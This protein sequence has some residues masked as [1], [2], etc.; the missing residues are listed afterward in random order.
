MTGIKKLMYKLG[1]LICLGVVALFFATCEPVPDH[2]GRAELYNPSFQFCFAGKAYNKCSGKTY[3]PLTQGCTDR[4]EVGT[5]CLDSTFVKLGTPCNG[6][7]LSVASAPANGGEVTLTPNRT[8]FAADE[9]VALSATAMDGYMFIGWAGASTSASATIDVRMD[10]NKPLVAIFNPTNT[11]GATTHTLVT[12]AFPEHSGTVFVNSAASTGTTTHDNGAEITVSAKA[13]QGYVFSGWSGALTSE[14]SPTA[15]IM[16]NSKTLVA[17]FTLVVYTLTVGS[18][19]ETGGTVFV[20]GTALK[21]VVEQNVGAR[22][23]VYALPAA[24]Y[25]FTGW[26]VAE[27]GAENPEW[28]TVTES[29]Q[30]LIANFTHTGAIVVNPCADD[31]GSDECCD[32]NPTHLSCVNTFTDGRDG[33]VYRM[34]TI[35]TQAWMAENLNF[36]ADGSVCYDN[37]SNNCNTYGRLYDWATV[38]DL[39]SNCNFGECAGQVQYRHQGICPLGWYVPSDDEWQTLIDFVGINPGAKLKSTSGWAGDGHGSD[40]FG[41]SA[42]PGGGYNNNTGSFE[43]GMQGFWWSA[44]ESDIN[45]SR[46]TIHHTSNAMSGYNNPKSTMFSLRCIQNDDNITPPTTHTLTTT[47]HLSP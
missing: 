35:G 37:D 12:T 10:S 30:R 22:V 19:P 40:R 29:N 44:T 5:R 24:G 4:N 36:A 33:Q 3:N 28:I 7:T 42:M 16:D 26:S 31:L 23:R 32:A 45:A 41:F 21:G 34:V 38:M 46:W 17:M 25:V 13:A 6:Y 9:Q 8:N 1:V 11:A 43:V 15:I 2:C 20:D 14:A 18:N 39:S 27:M 47:E